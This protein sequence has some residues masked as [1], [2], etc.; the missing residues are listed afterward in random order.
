[1]RIVLG[2]VPWFVSIPM[3]FA[4]EPNPA[5]L[6]IPADRHADVYA[7]YSA[8]LSP[9]QLGHADNNEKYLVTEL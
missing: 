5:V 4:Q 3:A 8:V 2:A 6:P 7:I 9:P 1:M